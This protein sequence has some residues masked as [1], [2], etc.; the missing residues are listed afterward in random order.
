[1]S[2]VVGLLFGFHT[3]YDLGREGEI[4]KEYWLNRS[5]EEA[6]NRIF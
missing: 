1:M 4:W 5:R 2:V 6:S 3:K